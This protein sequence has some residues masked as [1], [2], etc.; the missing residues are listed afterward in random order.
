[1]N[2]LIA[3]QDRNVTTTEGEWREI[4]QKAIMHRR[5][6]IQVLPIRDNQ[7]DAI[8]N[9]VNRYMVNALGCPMRKVNPLERVGR[10]VLCEVIPSRMVDPIV[11]VPVVHFDGWRKFVHNRLYSDLIDYLLRYHFDYVYYDSHPSWWTRRMN[12]LI[13]RLTT[14]SKVYLDQ[15]ELVYYH[16]QLVECMANPMR[17]TMKEFREGRGY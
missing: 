3:T 12:K 14:V 2:K 15:D 9:V 16:N 8:T 6:D 5:H 7:L 11:P 17:K 4:G 13:S 1:M 10:V